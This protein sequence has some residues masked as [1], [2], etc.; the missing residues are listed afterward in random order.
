MTARLL[1][2]AGKGGVGK[3]S[4][5]CATAIHYADLGRKVLIVA[6][7]SASNLGDLFAQPIGSEITPIEGVR[8]L[9]A[10]A[11]LSDSPCA[12]MTG[13]EPLTTQFDIVVFDG[14][15]GSTAAPG[16]LKDAAQACFTFVLQP[17]ASSIR[18]TKRSIE[19]LEALGI[20]E[21]SLIINGIIPFAET[22][23]SFFRDRSTMQQVHLEGIYD[24]LPYPARKMFLLDSE[25]SGIGGLRRV[26]G[27]LYGGD[28]D[29]RVG[30]P[31]GLV[32]TGGPDAAAAG[33][34]RAA[35]L[36]RILPSNGPRTIFFAGKGGV[37]KTVLSSVTAAWLA[38]RGH[39]TLLLTADPQGYMSDVLG[40]DV[41]AE[42]SP[43]PGIPTLHVAH[44]AAFEKF[45]DYASTEEWDAVVFDTAPTGHTLRM[46]GSPEVIDMMGDP[47]KCT[48]AYVMYP[49]RAPIMESARAMDDLRTLGIEPGLI[50]ADQV[51][52]AEACSTPYAAA[53][54]R[55][56]EKHLADL[57]K[58]FD[59][60]VLLV[61]MLPTEVTGIDM[62]VSLGDLIYGL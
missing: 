10:M 38:K 35:A 22:V 4:M 23:N 49:E 62:L 58:R 27:M 31:I 8:S 15:V 2:F 16:V 39:R 1:F 5:A 28:A 61:P 51:L 11:A 24:D 25:I 46:Q 44:L 19:E 55:M 20:E 45:I 54:R 43:Y 36:A 41:T 26:A 13:A 40:V 48:F 33:E 29:Y 34:T 53:R 9:W 18:E 3:T 30:T 7:E 21:F 12:A 47:S 37:G 60:P 32:P 6:I 56:Q 42:Q 59:L 52:P 50:L 17:E 57:R 14:C